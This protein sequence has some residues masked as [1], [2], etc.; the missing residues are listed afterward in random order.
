M[1][2]YFSTT[3]GFAR[4]DTDGLVGRVY[5]AFTDAGAPFKT[6]LAWGC[7]PDLTLAEITEWNQRRLDRGF[8][9]GLTEHVSNDYRQVLLSLASYDEVRL[10]I[11]LDKSTVT[12]D[13]IVSER[14]VQRFGQSAI[15]DCAHRVWD[16]ARPLWIQTHFENG[17][18]VPERQ[19]RFGLAPSARPFAFLDDSYPVPSSDRHTV[20]LLQRGVLVLSRSPAPE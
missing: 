3:F 2:P 18:A 16:K 19:L 9:L 17:A 1:P 6:V 7:D 12:F 15:Q 10:F 20:V 4:A 13:L 5:S 14:D 8:R 11:G